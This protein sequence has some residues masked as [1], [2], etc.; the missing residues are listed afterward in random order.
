[1]NITAHNFKISK[2]ERE[3]ITIQPSQNQIDFTSN[4]FQTNNNISDNTFQSNNNREQ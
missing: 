3:N 2:S 4:T 1:M